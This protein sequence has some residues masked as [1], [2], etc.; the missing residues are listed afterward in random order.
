MA[1]RR[2]DVGKEK[3]SEYI[4]GENEGNIEKEYMKF[5]VVIVSKVEAITL[6]TNYR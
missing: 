3:T 4:I 2:E 6:S 1:S 5:L